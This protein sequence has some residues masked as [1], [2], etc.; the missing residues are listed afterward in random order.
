LQSN[1]L[2]LVTRCYAVWASRTLELDGRPLDASKAKELPERAVLEKPELP[3][4]SEWVNDFAKAG[5][6]FGISFAGKHLSPDNLGRL[7]SA[8]DQKVA[9]IGAR[10]SDITAALV[11][12]VGPLG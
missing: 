2:D 12:R 10:P 11:S 3:S 6:C 9:E 4:Q 7:R 8:L 5:Q 1:A